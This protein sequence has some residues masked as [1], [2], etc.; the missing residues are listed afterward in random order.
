MIEINRRLSLPEEEIRFE[1]SPSS[2]PGGQHVNRTETRVTLLFDVE[3]SRSLTEGQKAIIQKSL[4]S[5]INRE[6]L[7]RVSVQETRSQH[8]NREIAIRRFVELLRR[9]LK[10]RRRR[11]ST[12]PPRWAREKRLKEKRIRSRLKRRRS[13]VDPED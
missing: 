4:S 5:R 9:A 6:G 2:G 8:A 1:T 11:K 3:N 10:P 12:R 7:L 13:G